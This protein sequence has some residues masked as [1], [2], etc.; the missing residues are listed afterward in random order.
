[1]PGGSRKWLESDVQDVR[2]FPRALPDLLKPLG[3]ARRRW[4]NTDSVLK[5]ARSPLDRQRRCSEGCS[6]TLLEASGT[7]WNVP[8][9]PQDAPGRSGTLPGASKTLHDDPGG[10]K[11]YACSVFCGTGDAMGP[12]KVANKGYPGPPKHTIFHRFSIHDNSELNT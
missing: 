8:G 4:V 12:A 2:S 1:M 9:G 5:G 7:L 10:L 3:E 6:G 11:H